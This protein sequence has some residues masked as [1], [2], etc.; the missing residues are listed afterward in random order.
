[1]NN[2]E[3]NNFEKWVIKKRSI[4]FHIIIGYLSCFIW[5]IIY[6]YCKYKSDKINKEKEEKL[7]QQKEEL[8]RRKNRKKTE[9]IFNKKLKV[10]ETSHPSRQKLLKVI[11]TILENNDTPDIS[12][13]ISN[14]SIDFFYCDIDDDLMDDQPIGILKDDC[15]SELKKYYDSPDYDVFMDYEVEQNDDFYSLYVT[16]KVYN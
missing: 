13:S 4:W 1:M 11:Y 12:A 9:L 14:K 10:S 6:F 15:C 7:K 3:L 8:T 16:I 2:N 5:L